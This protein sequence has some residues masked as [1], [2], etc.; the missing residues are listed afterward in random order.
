LRTRTGSSFQETRSQKAQQSYLLF[1]QWNVRGTSRHNKSTNTRW[2]SMFMVVTQRLFYL[3][4][5]VLS[6]NGL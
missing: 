5:K 1:G 3:L 2:G 6:M 4:T